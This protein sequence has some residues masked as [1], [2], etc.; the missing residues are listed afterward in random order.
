MDFEELDV[1]CRT[2]PVGEHRERP[3]WKGTAMVAAQFTLEDKIWLHVAL[4]D[5]PSEAG[6]EHWRLVLNFL[7]YRAKLHRVENITGLC[8]DLQFALC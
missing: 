5:N 7:C 2:S 1:R 8:S 3:L 6:L 4:V